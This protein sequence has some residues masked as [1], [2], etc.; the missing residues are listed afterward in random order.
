MGSLERVGDIGKIDTYTAA[1]AGAQ[2]VEEACERLASAGCTTQLQ[3]ASI[4]IDDGEATASP[5]EGVNK[6]G[7][8]FF[9]WCLHNRDGE[10]A[11]CVPRGPNGSCP[12]RH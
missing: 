2:T 11:R 5:F 10:L 7:D 4:V 1:V 8:A 6:I 9:L 3:D 12:P